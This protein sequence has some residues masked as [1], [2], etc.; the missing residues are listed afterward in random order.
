LTD[1]SLFEHL[2][3]ELADGWQGLPDKPEE[4]PEGTLHA[5]WHAAAGEPMCVERAASVPLP[6]LCETRVTELSALVTRRLAGVPL[7]HLTGRQQFMGIEMLAGPQ[8]LIPRKETEILGQ[9]AQEELRRLVEERGPATVIDLCTGC[10][11]VVLALAHQ[12]PRGR[13]L[14]SD[15]CP[16]ALDLARQNARHLGLEPRV[17][18][19][20]GDLLAAFDGDF[21]GQVDLITCNPPYIS[22]LKVGDMPDEISA[23]EP[24]LAFD[25]GSFGV[26]ILFRLVREA[27]VFLKPDSCLCL[28]V[29]RGQGEPLVSRLTKGGQFREVRGVSDA[30]GE[31]RALVA[32]TW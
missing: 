7:A 21:L 3:A 13:F 28:E 5:L 30:R 16:E 27:P 9:A 24:R 25:G 17:E 23:H 11:N 10:G 26:T 12:E 6:S 2:L 29:G 22:S 8:A 14:A 20:E 4:T 31:I 32:R 19:R 1:T 15:L 18:F